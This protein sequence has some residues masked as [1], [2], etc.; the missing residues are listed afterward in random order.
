[1]RTLR[2]HSSRVSQRRLEKGQC[3][4]Q[5][6][7]PGPARAAPVTLG[8]SEMEGGPQAPPRGPLSPGLCRSPLPRLRGATGRL[9][10]LA[11]ALLSLQAAREVRV[12]VPRLEMRKPG[13]RGWS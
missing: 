9:E 4:G 6:A 7:G 13:L 12:V 11:D 8:H 10:A 3:S 2:N 1:M 5:P